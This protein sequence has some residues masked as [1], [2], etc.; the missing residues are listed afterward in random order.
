MYRPFDA[1]R[2]TGKCV[3]VIGSGGKTT[4]LRYLA[5]RLPGS[6]VLTTSTHIFPFPDLPLVDTG[7]EN[8]PESRGRIRAEIRAALGRSRMICLGRLLPSGKLSS[9]APFLPFEELLDETDCLLVEADGAAG[10]PLK[11][12]RPWEPVIPACSGGTV[13]VVGASGLGKPAAEAC[14][15]PELFCALAGISPDRPVE[16]EHVAAVLN[17]EALADY[18]LVNQADALP[19]METARRLCGL[20]GRDAGFCSLAPRA[21]LPPDRGGERPPEQ[22]QS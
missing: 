12:H 4:L 15:C 9:P 10:R 20:I 22:A 5:E 16:P 1:F 7:E 17:R 2:V 13:C 6:V 21:A 19:D 14:H 8:T 11:A 3:S 18:Y